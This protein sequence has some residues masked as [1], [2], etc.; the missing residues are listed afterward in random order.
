MIRYRCP[1][2]AALTVAHER[3]A[4]QSSVCKA[5]LK[6][7]QIPADSALWLT[8]TGELLHPP[9]AAVS[10]PPAPV[11]DLDPLPEPAVAERDEL[12]VTL[13]DLIFVGVP[14]EP[15]PAATPAPAFRAQSH[16]PEPEPEPT[17]VASEPR[18]ARPSRFAPPE[19]AEEE[20]EEPAAVATVP[21]PSVPASTPPPRRRFAGPRPANGATPSPSYAEPVQLQTQAD[22][23]VALTNALASRMKPPPAPRRDLLP[24]TAIWMLLT[25]I[26]AALALVTLFTDLGYRWAA[27]AVG[28]VQLLIGY[29]WIVRLTY[30]RDPMRG[31]V[32]A[33]PPAACYYLSQR[34]YAKLRPLRFALTGAA[35]IGLGLAAPALAD[36]V[37]PLVAATDAKPADGAKSRLDRLRLYREQRA[38]HPLVALLEELAKTDPDRS[39]DAGDRAELA[40]ELKALC[41]HELTDVRVEAMYAFTLW[42]EPP[43]VTARAVCLAAVRSPTQQERLRALQLLP[44][45]KDAESARAVQSLIGPDG[46]ETNQAKKSLEEIGGPPAEQAALALLKRAEDMPTRL[47]AVGILEKVGGPDAAKELRTYAM[48]AEEVAV[49][50]RALTSAAAIESRTKPK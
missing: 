26:G 38:Y 36:R 20:Q 3:R 7:H 37:R 6:T 11:P 17:V 45:W 28:L 43:A 35:L 33:V 42:D 34:K 50:N 25:G 30:L 18:V 40:A 41:K 46:V 27:L 12:A 32:C 47:T 4:G 9:A 48:V 21:P 13:P 29:G 24:S 31:L 44:H 5:C 49:R 15:E 23:A 10:E 22:I 14:P 1:H 16:A 8:E 2:C 19:P 39:V